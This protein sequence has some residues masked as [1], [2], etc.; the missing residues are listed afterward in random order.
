MHRALFNTRCWLAVLC[1]AC[2]LAYWR[3]LYG[4]FLFD[5]F[6]NIVT[7]P[8]LQAIQHGDKPDWLMVMFL[9]GSGILRRPISM[10]SFGLNVYAFGMDPFAFKLVNVLIHLASGTLLYALFR[11]IAGRLAPTAGPMRSDIVAF[12]GAAIWLLHPLHVSSVL[13]IVQRM[14]LLATMFVLAGL[15][16]YTEGRLRMLRGETGLLSALSGL[17][18]F[19]LLAVFSKENGALIAMYALAIELS[20]FR[21]TAP[22]R[23][24]SAL[25]AFFC[26][27]V[28]LPAVLYAVHLGIHPESLAYARNGFTLYTRLISE[29][30]VLC[31]YLLWIFVPIPSFMGMYHDDIAV[32][33]GLFAPISTVVSIGFL[34]ALCVGAW[35][36]RKRVPVFAFGVAWFLIGHS[37][38]STIFPLELVFEHRNYLPMAG[39]LLAAVSLLSSV[40]VG[41]RPSARVIAACGAI[42]IVLLGGITAI[43]ADSWGSALSL[44]LADVAHHP[45]SSRSQYEAGRAIAA[46]AARDGTLDKATP[47]AIAHLKRAAE[48]D[49]LQVF[50]GVSMI[51]LRGTSAPVPAAEVADLAHRLEHAASN[52]QANPF[53]QLLVAAS[54]GQLGLTPS[55]VS[56]LFEAARSNPRW[57]PQVRAMMLNDYGAY[58]F[59]VVRDQEEAVRLTTAAAALD[60][61]SPYFQL[62]LAK[63]AS[64]MGRTEAAREHLAAAGALDKTGLYDGDI[65][66]LQRQLGR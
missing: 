28:A 14:N 53:L 50:P 15:L 56:T 21:F 19:G 52:E 65:K 39:P 7:N 23:A 26:T 32:S 42:A 29:A 35:S 30:R 40:R 62:N 18:L 11:R 58:M 1:V 5:D 45:M 25:I 20:C 51:L 38:E 49:P 24:R 44:A 34:A 63:I 33:S 9:T 66:E 47:Q 17:C 2:A 12:F 46:A 16:C 37:L 59:N 22:T 41:A 64:G 43:R 57:R 31:D 54:N 10:L 27:T 3:G 36:L 13:Y 61:T 8:A 6:P 55:D 60:P 48:L 4:D